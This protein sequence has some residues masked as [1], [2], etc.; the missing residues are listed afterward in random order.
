MS[1]RR[2]TGLEA[3]VRWRHPTLGTVSPAEFIPIAERTGAS[4][5][6]TRWVLRTALSQLARWVER[7]VRVEMA[8]NFSATDILDRSMLQHVL[9]VLRDTQVPA[10]SLTV[11][12]TESV[13]L[14]EPEAARQNMELL[15]V[16]GVRFSIDDFGTGYSSLSQLR[17]LAADELKIDQSFVRRLTDA[18][19]HQ[20]V[21]RAIIDLAHGL[22]LR[23][24]A[25]GVETE[26]QWRQLVELGCDYAQGY[27]TGKPQSAEDL[28]PVLQSERD[29]SA[30][31][32]RTS[33]L[34]V[35]ELRRSNEQ[36]Q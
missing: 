6:L 16:A 10:G 36:G 12:I 4:G 17:D 27:L 11:E 7:G 8:V 24:V 29:L 30:E 15:R 13:L 14:H 34:R 2:V 32:E 33:S 23:T 18:P 21:I 9:E 20:A 5:A 25:E 35:L 26:A 3:L 22:G 31:N 1:D 28:V 19:E